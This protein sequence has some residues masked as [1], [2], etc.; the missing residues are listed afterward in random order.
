MHGRLLTAPA[1]PF[2]HLGAYNSAAAPQTLRFAMDVHHEILPDRYVLMLTESPVSANGTAADT[3][4]RCLQQAWRSGKTS[5]WVDCSRL[6]HMPTAA[7][8]LLL[9]YQKRLGRRSVRLVLSK[10][11]ARVQQAFADVAPDAR[12]EIQDAGTQP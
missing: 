3:L 11:N 5:V 7:R 4:A 1:L 10:P 2:R 8:E 9:R 12:P 6:H